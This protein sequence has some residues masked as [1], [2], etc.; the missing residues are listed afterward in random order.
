MSRV[1][2]LS[3]LTNYSL[4]SRVCGV[5]GFRAERPN[6]TDRIEILLLVTWSFGLLKKAGGVALLEKDGSICWGASRSLCCLGSQVRHRVVL[7]L[8]LEEKMCFLRLARRLVSGEKVCPPGN[9][10]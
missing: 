5:A 6:F 10:G 9:G 8:A 7:V 2:A 1:L 3:F 4:R